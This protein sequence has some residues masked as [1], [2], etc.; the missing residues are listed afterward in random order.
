MLTEDFI[1]AFNSR[2][3]V[4]ANTVK[5]LTVSEQDRVK[6]A[7][8]R[9]EALLKNRDFAQFVHGFKI[10]IAEQLVEIAGHTEV[11]NSRRIA[12]SNQLSGIDSFIAQLKEAVYWK[13]QL[14][15][16]A[17]TPTDLH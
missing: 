7:G 16:L 13:H 15:K 10:S 2:V 5:K 17:T 6:D 3:V 12:L 14:V 1:Q 4:N 8:T 9:A 11:D